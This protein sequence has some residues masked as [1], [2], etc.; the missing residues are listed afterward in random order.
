MTDPAEYIANGKIIIDSDPQGAQIFING[1]YT[2]KVTPDSILLLESGLYRTKLR[3]NPYLD[4]EDSITVDETG[5]TLIFKSFF[6]D[7]RN[8]G[9][10]VC[11]SEPTGVELFIN[12]SSTG[13]SSPHTFD[14]L[15][16]GYYKVVCTYPD[17][18]DQKILLFIHGGESK[19]ICFTPQDTSQCVD[20]NPSNSD[21][22]SFNTTCVA[23]DNDNFK[24]IGLPG[25]GLV[26]YN[27]VS[28]TKYNMHNSEI[29]SNYV[30][31]ITI[32]N[33]DRIWVGTQRGIL[34]ID[35]NKNWTIYTPDN[36][37]MPNDFIN[38]IKIDSK[39]IAWIAAADPIGGRY[40]LKFDGTSWNSYECPPERLIICLAIDNL[41]RLWVGLDQGLR[42]FENEEWTFP[43]GYYS[44]QYMVRK[45]ATE[46]IA[47]DIDGRMWMGFGN[48][49]NGRGDLFYYDGAA[50]NL[51]EL[52]EKTV[53][54]IYMSESGNKWIS[55]LGKT[56]TFD[57]DP[58]RPILIKIDANDNII[59]FSMESTKMTSGLL[60][61][62]TAQ[63]NGD[64]WIASRDKGLIKFKGANL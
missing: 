11:L 31:C 1:D 37:D 61:W 13:Q 3:L 24:W 64:L 9:K 4:I 57:I 6:E 56:P 48:P 20:Y 58:L 8:Y 26:K 7:L 46:S 51:F 12:D 35:E 17:Y 15:W 44:A 2:G 63:S 10:I 32:D 45:Y 22:P 38:D 21:F 49:G 28:V 25:T 36:S 55:C 5:L 34:I 41:E 30:N 60:R 62:S 14:L 39:G 18:R 23:I 43:D 19:T 29:P 53:S 42:I 40:L 27:E 16:P 33:R 47:L 59:P 52:P 50:F 54:H